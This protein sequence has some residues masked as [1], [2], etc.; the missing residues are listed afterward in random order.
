MGCTMLPAHASSMEIRSPQC[1]ATH[2]ATCKL[3]IA[4]TVL[5]MY[6]GPTCLR[7]VSVTF[8]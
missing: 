6:V 8:L 2:N 4:N 3:A 7:L 1:C 5:N